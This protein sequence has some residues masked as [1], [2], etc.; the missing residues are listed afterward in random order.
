MIIDSISPKICN[1]MSKV[2]T[3]KTITIK[4]IYTPGSE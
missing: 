3:I 2:S 4:Q 1:L